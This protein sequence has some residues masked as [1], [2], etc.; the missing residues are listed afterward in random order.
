M[1][2]SCVSISFT[3]EEQ[4]E[5]ISV[6]YLN[7]CVTALKL[8]KQKNKNCNVADTIEYIQRED[9]QKQFA[10]IINLFPRNN[11]MI[12]CICDALG[13][14]MMEVILKNSKGN[15]YRINFWPSDK[16]QL[17]VEKDTS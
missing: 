13:L 15:N 8:F 2:N 7:D 14:V 9:V 17:V 10:A 4:N 3:R 11:P 16:A 5:I 6:E 1:G 12:M